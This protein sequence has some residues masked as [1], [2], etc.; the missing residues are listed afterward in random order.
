VAAAIGR[1]RRRGSDPVTAPRYSIVIPTF[2]RGE[3]LAECLE[4]VCALDY[5][6]EAI[7]VVIVDNGGAENTKAAATPFMDRLRIRYLV[8]PRNRGYGF[9]VNRGIVESAGD[10]ILLLN[11]DARPFPD[12]LRECDRLLAADPSIGCVGCRAIEHG[13]Q[14]WGTRIGYIDRRGIIVGNFD[15]D[16]GAP[17]EVEHVYGFCYVFTREAVER[18]GLNDVTLLAQPYSSGNCIET[19]HCL[20]IRRAGL[21]VVYNPRMAAR[22]LAKPRPD[23]SEVSLRWHLNAIRNP[24]YLFLKHYGVFGNG[25]VALRLTFFQHVGIVSALRRPSKANLA[26]FANGLRARASAYGHYLKYLVGPRFDSPEAFK[27]V[28]DADMRASGAI[29][30]AGAAAPRSR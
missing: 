14:N 15:V 4:S 11:D 16:C 28:L 20:S 9:S 5:E 25:A 12:M 22:H 26:Y 6:H 2:R 27:R 3:S 18:A 17:V 1:A 10:R 29:D 7:E 21:K 19:D 30:L 13:Y 23:M 8:N 24:L